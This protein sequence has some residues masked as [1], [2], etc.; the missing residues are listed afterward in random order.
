MLKSSI[1]GIMGPPPILAQPTTISPL[2]PATLVTEA[3]QQ[4]LYLS[5]PSSAATTD[6]AATSSS[7]TITRMKHLCIHPSLPH[8]VYELDPQQ[9]PH[10]SEPA[11]QTMIDPTTSDCTKFTM[12]RQLLFKLSLGDLAGMM[13]DND[14]A[15]PNETNKQ[16]VAFRSL[17]GIQWIAFFDLATM[18]ATYMVYQYGI[19][20]A[21]RWQ[22]F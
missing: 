20:G 7:S 22:Y 6:T 15:T 8:V 9:S 16:T 14:L 13:F 19:N 1:R 11:K 10:Q 2:N 17:G 12:T 4:S 18:H 3:L 5:I 21:T